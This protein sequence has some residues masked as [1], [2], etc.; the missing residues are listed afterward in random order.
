MNLSGFEISAIYVIKKIGK[1]KKISNISPLSTPGD[2]FFY[3]PSR[4]RTSLSPGDFFFLLSY[5]RRS[6]GS[7][8]G[9]HLPV[10]LSSCVPSPC[11]YFFHRSYHL[12]HASSLRLPGGYSREPPS[13]SPCLPAH[14]VSCS[15]QRR[16]SLALSLHGRLQLL[17]RPTPVRPLCGFSPPAPIQCS[18]LCSLSPPSLSGARPTV[19]SSSSAVSPCPW[20]PRRVPGS[21]S[22][23][24]RP[25]PSPVHVPTPS[26][27]VSSARARCPSCSPS[28][29]APAARR[30]YSSRPRD[31][32][33]SLAVVVACLRATRALL[34]VHAVEVSSPCALA[35]AATDS[36]I[37]LSSSPTLQL[38]VVAKTEYHSSFQWP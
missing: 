12:A 15:S 22:S 24:Q 33:S 5:C 4:L 8:Y 26:V 6:L 34:A 30:L 13:A 2:F 1:I 7:L 16:P 14:C 37:E 23:V 17:A 9:G 35:S 38:A 10:V 3:S 31:F 21:R 36:A 18:G 11:G 25:A 28:S 32:L 27:P 19:V 29:L 20:P